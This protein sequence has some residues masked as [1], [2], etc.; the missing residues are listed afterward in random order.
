MVLTRKEAGLAL[1]LLWS[2]FAST[3]SRGQ[4]SE[5]VSFNGALDYNAIKKDLAVFQGV[6]DTTVKQIVQ[7]PFSILGSTK[8]TYL[9]EYGA[10]F[11]LEVNF[12]QIRQLSPF[13]FRPHTEKELNDAYNLM[14]KRVETLKEGLVKAMGEHGSSLGQLKPNDYLTVVVHLFS[15]EAE[16]KRPA[17]SQMIL[18]VKKSF[19]SDYRENKLA[20]GDLAK[21]VELVQF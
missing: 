2:L 3:V 4:G 18:R 7:G 20:P 6:I 12:Y 17:P 10:V 1:V 8:G 19:I 15:V 13:D 11:N 21:K 5:P 14:M 16:A 9:P